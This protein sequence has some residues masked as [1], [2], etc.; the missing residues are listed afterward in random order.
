MALPIYTISKS[1]ALPFT[2]LK[3]IR[4]RPQELVPGPDYPCLAKVSEPALQITFSRE[5]KNPELGYLLGSDRE[6]CDILL[7]CPDDSISHLMFAISFNQYNEPTSHRSAAEIK[8]SIVGH[9]RETNPWK[10]SATIT[11]P[12]DPILIANSSKGDQCAAETWESNR[13]NGSMAKD[14][15]TPGAPRRSVGNV[16]QQIS[17]HPH[18]AAPYSTVHQHTPEAVVGSDIDLP[19]MDKIRNIL[20]S[21]DTGDTGD[22]GDNNVGAE[23]FDE[24][25]VEEIPRNSPDPHPDPCT[26]AT[27]TSRPKTPIPSQKVLLNDKWSDTKRPGSQ[28]NTQDTEV[29]SKSARKHRAY[30]SARKHRAN[31]H[32]RQWDTKSARNHRASVTMSTEDSG[33]IRQIEHLT[34]E[35]FGS[36]FVNIRAELRSKNL[37]KSTHGEYESEDSTVTVAST[38]TETSPPITKKQEKAMKD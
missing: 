24:E 16:L 38:D 8:M 4:D 25:D 29:L 17:T 10:L 9:H 7:G 33:T 5:P 19:N 1:C 26:D 21:G 34:G 20:F 15:L 18:D 22:V 23:G 13:C 11:H 32:E 30:K 28:N 12:F 3:Y 2:T 36:W 35:N 31:I 37:W 14:Q 27:Y 6:L